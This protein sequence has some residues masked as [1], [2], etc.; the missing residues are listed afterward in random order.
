[1]AFFTTMAFISHLEKPNDPHGSGF[2]GPL[3]CPTAQVIVVGNSYFILVTSEENLH[4][5]NFR[6]KR[7][8]V[9]YG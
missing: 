2:N 1:M 3:I 4:S 7:D 8:K 5:K 9:F 6:R